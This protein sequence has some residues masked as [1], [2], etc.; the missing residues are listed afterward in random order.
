MQSLFQLGT[1]AVPIVQSLLQSRWLTSSWDSW[2]EQAVKEPPRL[3]S[4]RAEICGPE[5]TRCPLVPSAL[6]QNLS[7]LRVEE[8]GCVGS[9]QV[10]PAV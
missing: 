2:P 6:R 3:I 4:A 9:R 8:P 5:V 10:I 1:D 7:R